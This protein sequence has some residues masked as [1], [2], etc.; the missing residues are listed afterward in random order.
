NIFHRCQ[1]HQWSFRSLPKVI[2]FNRIVHTYYT[3][4]RITKIFFILLSRNNREPVPKPDLKF[5]IL[6]LSKKLIILFHNP[7]CS[8]AN[9]IKHK[10]SNRKLIRLLFLKMGGDLLSH[11]SAVPSALTG[12]TS[13][14]GM[15]RGGAPLL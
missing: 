5:C 2:V 13:L 14:F 6:F 7:T 12:L 10:N 11:I 15:G 9:Y 3:Y 8:P 1:H 4:H